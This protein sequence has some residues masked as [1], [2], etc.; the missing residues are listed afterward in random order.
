LLKFAKDRLRW[1]QWLFEAK[2]R[3]GLTILDYMATSN[4]IHLLVCDDAGRDVI[5]KSIQLLAGRTGQG[6]NQRKKRKGAYWQDRYH[7]TAV[8]TGDHLLQC[9]VYIDLNMVR[10]GKIRHPSHWYWSGYNEIQKPKRKNV[11]INYAKLGQLAGFEN[12]AGFQ[13]AHKRWIEDSLGKSEFARKSQ[14]TESVAV[15]SGQ[16]VKNI[17]SQMGAR[18]KGRSVLPTEKSFQ[19]REQ[20]TSYDSHF[21][22]EKCDIA[23]E[24]THLWT[25][26]VDFL[27]G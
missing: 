27:I 13:S 26:I 22:T 10:A 12:F 16:F 19:L 15:G 25:D 21:D 23:T 20:T 7:A 24:S 17:R 6:Y 14:W 8:E 18:A 2:K 4:H 11:L 9:I 1:M 5:S 3:Y